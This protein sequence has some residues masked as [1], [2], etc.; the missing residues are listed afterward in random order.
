MSTLN[1]I[2]RQA[3]STANRAGRSVAILNL[4]RIGAALYVVR[5]W[6]EAIEADRAFVERVSPQASVWQ[7]A[8]DADSYGPNA[9]KFILTTPDGE[10]ELSGD[11]MFADEAA[12]V[13]YAASVGLT[14]V[15]LELEG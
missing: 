3:Q 9:V 1:S 15:P 8:A 11:E 12:A 4:N 10:N 7:L 2:R 6:S 13:A 5:Q 14:I